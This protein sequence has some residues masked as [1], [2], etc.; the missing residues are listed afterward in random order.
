MQDVQ[1]L[2]DYLCQ[3][4]GT[5]AEYLLPEFARYKIGSLVT[6]VIIGFILLIIGIKLLFKAITE[7]K[8]EEIEDDEAILWLCG[9]PGLIVS[10]INLIWLIE[11]L[12][13]LIGYLCSPTAGALKD[14][15]GM[16]H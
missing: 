3:K 9:V 6:Q 14:I 10:V 11:V 13:N 5:T 8:K 12:P 16:L 7:F 1:Q 15:A 4:L 2:I